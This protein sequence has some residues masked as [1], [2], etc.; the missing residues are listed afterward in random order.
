MTFSVKLVNY[1]P[2]AENN[3]EQY[4]K[5]ITVQPGSNDAAW[6]DVELIFT[7]LSIFDTLLFELERIVD[8]YKTEVRYPIIAYVELSEINNVIDDITGKDQELIKIGVQSR[9]GLTMCINGEE[10]HIG[11]SGIYELK[12]GDIVTNFFSVVNGAVEDT[13]AVD[14]YMSDVNQRYAQATTEEERE[15]IKS[16]CFFNTDTRYYPKTRTIDSFTLDYVYKEK[17]EE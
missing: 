3:I 2:T 14:D 10:I 17:E 7:P 16:Q 4:I 11:R 8:D 6:A 12:N 5:T 15:Q 1:E 13:S 9:P